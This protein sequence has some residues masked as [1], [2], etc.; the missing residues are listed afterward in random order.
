MKVSVNYRGLHLEV[1]GNAF[2]AQGDGWNE[3]LEEAYFDADTIT[4]EGVNICEL[5]S[6]DQWDDICKLAIEECGK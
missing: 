5:L 1:E 6:G 4:L 3:P 2:P